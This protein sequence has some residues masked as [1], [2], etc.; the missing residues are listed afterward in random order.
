[1]R[2]PSGAVSGSVTLAGTASTADRQ[3]RTLCSGKAAAWGAAVGGWLLSSVAG[4]QQFH[5]FVAEGGR[6]PPCAP[7]AERIGETRASRRLRALNRKMGF[8]KLGSAEGG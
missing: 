2:G 5:L 6:V 1:M 8:I 4:G 7:T 3:L